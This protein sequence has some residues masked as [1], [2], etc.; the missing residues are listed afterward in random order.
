[1][2]RIF[3]ISLAAMLFFTSS[4]VKMTKISLDKNVTIKLPSD[5]VVMS[6]DDI[7]AKYPAYRKPIATYI[8]PDRLADF[9][10]N[11]TNGVWG[12]DIK[13][14]KDVY[15]ATIQNTYSK[16]E[17][18]QDTII[19][20]KKRNYVVFEYVS[21][22]EDKSASQSSKPVVRNY[23][24]AKYALQNGEIYLMRFNCPEK[25]KDKYQP[26]AQEIMKSVKINLIPNKHE[27]KTIESNKKNPNKGKQMENPYKKK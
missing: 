12:N 13:L 17:F 25:Y 1:M 20:I 19:K 21:E 24:Y 9:S 26:A 7:A 23:T 22:I 4:Q 11:V 6:D 8:S 14:L 3:I 16:V 5:F 10:Y 2:K 15:K 27:T 18:I